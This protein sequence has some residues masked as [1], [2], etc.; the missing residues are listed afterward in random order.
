MSKHQLFIPAAAL[1]AV[2]AVCV[3]AIAAG[4]STKEGVYTA[5][6]SERGKAVFEKSCKNCHPPEF[7]AERIVRYADKPMN[8]FFEIISTTMPADNAGAL[9]TSEYVDVMAYILEITG[10]PAGKA[11]LSTDNMEGVTLAKP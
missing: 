8:D 10:S 9:L 6:Q 3:T 2:L 1:T 4:R 7:Y 5:A 11:E